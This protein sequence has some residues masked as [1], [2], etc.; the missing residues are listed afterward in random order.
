MKFFEPQP[1]TSIGV[2][3]DTKGERMMLEFDEMPRVILVTDKL[4]HEWDPEAPSLEELGYVAYDKDILMRATYYARRPWVWLLKAGLWAKYMWFKAVYWSY[5]RLWHLSSLDD[6]RFR[7]S[8]LRPG[9]GAMAQARADAAGLRLQIESQYNEINELKKGKNQAYRTGQ[10]KGWE[11]HV[12]VVEQFID[13]R[14]KGD[15]QESAD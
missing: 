14:V 9:T 2:Y 10:L 12:Q 11:Q 8:K 5:G 6:T 15:V 7:L 4:L 1:I 3:Y 13:E